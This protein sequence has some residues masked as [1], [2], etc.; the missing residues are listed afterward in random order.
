LSYQEVIERRF[1]IMDTTA[2]VL[3]RDNQ[4]PLRVV[5]MG[6]ENALLRAA[7]GEDE[8]TLIIAA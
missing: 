8:G 6:K 1:E 5:N 3:C 2:V 7:R 4:M